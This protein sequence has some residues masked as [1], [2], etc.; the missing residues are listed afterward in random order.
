MTSKRCRYTWNSV[1]SSLNFFIEELPF[2]INSHISFLDYYFKINELRSSL[3]FKDLHSRRTL[4]YSSLLCLRLFPSH[5][6]AFV[7][8]QCSGKNKQS[9]HKPERGYLRPSEASKLDAIDWSIT[10]LLIA[11]SF[12]LTPRAIFPTSS[13]SFSIRFLIA[14]YS[15]TVIVNMSLYLQ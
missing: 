14:E 13:I 8:S 9:V 2:S 1:I 3:R 6:Q 12:P 4:S 15:L 5:I 7:D 11:S 10:S